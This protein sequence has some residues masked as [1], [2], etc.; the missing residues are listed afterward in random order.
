MIIRDATPNDAMAICKIWN[1]VI[2]ET[3][4][5]FTSAP[6]TPVEVARMIADRSSLFLIVEAEQAVLGFATCGAFRA[7]PGYRYTLEHTILLRDTAQNQGVGRRL[8]SV[9]ESRAQ[10]SGARRLVAGISGSNDIAIAFHAA[11]GFAKVGQ[12]PGVG[13]KNGQWL[14]LVLMQKNL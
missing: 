8:M 7:G 1:A 10:A 11:L 6:K 4:I 5:T 13:Y 12:L 14:D 9:L 2:A 3:L